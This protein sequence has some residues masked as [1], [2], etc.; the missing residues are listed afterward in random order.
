MKNKDM[1]LDT[2]PTEYPILFSSEMI[3]AIFAS[4]KT[5]TRRLN[6]KRY[7]N[8]RKGDLLWVKETF[9]EGF[10]I[11]SDGNYVLDEYGDGIP[12]IWYRASDPGLCWYNNDSYFPSSPKWSPSL[13]MPKRF[14]RIWLEITDVHTEMLNDITEEDSL[15][16]G[17][18]SKEDFKKLWNKIN[19]NMPWDSN[20]RVYVI[21]FRRVI[22]V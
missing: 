4:K 2:K 12:Y 17:V 3:N 10:L 21:S 7:G 20:P 22:E 9:T 19:E 1:A 11:D 16:E 6:K 15:K 18:Q 8:Y 5:Q 13:F 14:S